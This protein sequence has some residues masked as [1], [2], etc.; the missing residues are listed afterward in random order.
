MVP[1]EDGGEREQNG[2]SEFIPPQPSSL[3]KGRLKLT[4]NIQGADAMLLCS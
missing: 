1:G 4:Q 3:H 2:Q